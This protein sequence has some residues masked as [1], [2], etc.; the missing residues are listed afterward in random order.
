LHDNLWLPRGFFSSLQFKYKH[1]NGFAPIRKV[2]T[3]WNLTQINI[4]IGSCGMVMPP[5]CLVLTFMRP[6]SG[7]YVTP[8]ANVMWQWR[9]KES[10][11]EGLKMTEAG[12]LVRRPLEVKDA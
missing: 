12:L 11:S 2:A 10:L 7:L 5:C 4:F 3:V 6:L 9:I 1:S 8:E